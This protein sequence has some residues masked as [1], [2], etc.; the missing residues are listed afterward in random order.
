MRGM[1]FG[2]LIRARGPELF[3]EALFVVFAVLVALAV[4]EWNE[5]RELR[6]QA[7]LARAA[8]VSELE[9]NREELAAGRESV[10]EMLGAVG[11][12]VESLRKGEEGPREGVSGVF[13]DFSDAAW[14]TARVTGAVARM[15][16]DWVL[17]AARVYEAQELT[18]DLQQEAIVL[19]G[20]IAVRGSDLERFT[21]F[22]GRLIIV[23]MLHENLAEMYEKVLGPSVE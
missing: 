8:V 9:S 21:D 11:K 7:D 17:T 4:D 1:S 12:V 20:E 22:Q 3:L 14:E 2:S 23:N 13:P 15:D 10:L 16:Y 19:F 5:S 6:S 18:L